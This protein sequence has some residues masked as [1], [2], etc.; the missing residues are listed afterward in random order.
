MRKC[1][2]VKRGFTLDP[3]IKGGKGYRRKEIEGELRR[4]RKV[5]GQQGSGLWLMM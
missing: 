4:E 2:L 3:R 1:N 5:M